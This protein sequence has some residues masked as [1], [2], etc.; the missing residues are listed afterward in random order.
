MNASLLVIPIDFLLVIHSE[1]F[2]VTPID[3]LHVIHSEFFGVTP[4]DFLHVISSDRRESR[5]LY[6]K[7]KFF[8]KNLE[9]QIFVVPLQSQT[10]AVVVKW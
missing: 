5:N 3:F 2:G 9:V 4:I 6:K 1:F 8:Q 10:Q 7:R